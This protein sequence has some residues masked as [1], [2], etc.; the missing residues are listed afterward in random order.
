[1]DFILELPKTIKHVDSIMVVVDRLSKI[2]HFVA[3]TK[4]SDVSH[5]A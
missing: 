1:M 4:I 5:V 3:S 2:V